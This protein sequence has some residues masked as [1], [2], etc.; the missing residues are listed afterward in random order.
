M[1]NVEIRNNGHV[2]HLAKFG[3][4]P[5]DPVLE[6]RGV[7]GGY[8]ESIVV[9]DVSITV[10]SGKVFALLGP[11]GAGKTTTLRIVAGMLRPASG[12]VVFNGEDVT[13]RSP[14]ERAARGLCLIP[15]GRGVFKSLTV[16]ENL[17]LFAPANKDGAKDAVERA[18]TV[19]P[20]LAD[21]MGDYAG[22]LSGGQ[23]QM[24]A[25]AR[26]YITNPKL[27]LLDE[28]SM[29]LAPLV[30]DEMF[31]VLSDLAKTGISMLIVEQYIN[32]AMA[33][34]DR[35]VLLNKGSVTYQGP[36]NELNEDVVLRGYLGVESDPEEP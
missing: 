1:T 2:Q 13:S 14:H 36:P 10:P 15:E 22:R 32:R 11:N 26:A 16:R 21:R 4:P 7:T 3:G 8:G 30:I 27:I 34:S 19:F 5:S 35:V 23:Q 24:L 29:G 6:I 18:V 20:A 33:M 17:R 31:S 12:R 25:V 9:H 28:V